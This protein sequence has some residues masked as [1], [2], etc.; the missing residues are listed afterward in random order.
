MFIS[1]RR[2]SYFILLTFF[3]LMISF[4]YDSVLRLSESKSPTIFTMSSIIDTYRSISIDTNGNGKKDIINIYID[5]KKKEYSIEIL[6]DDGTRHNISKS[7]EAKTFGHYISWWPLKVTVA[8]INI[9]N[10]PEIIFQLSEANDSNLSYIFR[11]DGRRYSNVLSGSFMGIYLLDV[12]K[13]SIPEVVTEEKASG[14][15]DAYSAYTWSAENYSKVNTDLDIIPRG[16]DKVKVLIDMLNTSYDDKTYD[17]EVL[18]TCFTDDWLN[19][20]KNILYLKSFAKDILSIQLQD[21]IGEDKVP[22]VKNN[23]KA[24][25]W[26]LRLIVFRKSGAEIK[27]E[28]YIAEIETQVS[29][30]SGN[31]HKIDTIK[32]KGQ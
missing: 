27:V 16:Y 13:D 5:N 11:W 29:I 23:P 6:N 21:Y 18:R 30:S 15:E 32:F 2:L 28:N 4:F 12:N 19:N 22:D 26:E 14:R 31:T 3:C 24:V 1:Y 7:P 20:S 17:L 9:D 10:M 8:D 25:R